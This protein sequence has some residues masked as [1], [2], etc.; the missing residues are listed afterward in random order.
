M[1]FASVP[2]PP[3]PFQRLRHWNLGQLRP[4]CLPACGSAR[5]APFGYFFRL[6]F[7]PGHDVNLVDLD[8]TLQ[9]HHWHFG[10]QAAAQLFRHGLNV[11]SIQ[12]QLPGDL[13]VG[14]VQAHE[15]EAQDP[16]PQRLVVPGQHRAGQVV[17]A[18]SACLA[19]VALPAGLRV[20]APVPDDGAA[21]THGAAHTF[22]PAVLAHQREALG[23]IQKRRKVD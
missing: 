14:K 11:R 21:V 3:L 18:A 10:D 20:V 8:L 9:L 17:E 13:P 12:A 22:R 19:P 2:R 23:V 6:P 16:N 4:A 15:V 7:V 1:S 5:A